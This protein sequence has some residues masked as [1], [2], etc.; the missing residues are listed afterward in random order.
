ME[1]Y[2]LGR[3]DLD[4]YGAEVGV[5][6]ISRL[7]GQEVFASV[8]DLIAQMARDVAAAEACLAG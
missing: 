4:L 5:D 6:L 1:A 7:R 3:D 8:E 2:A